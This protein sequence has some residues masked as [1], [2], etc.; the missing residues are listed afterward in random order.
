MR[1]SFQS[2]SSGEKV[3][4]RL[5]CHGGGWGRGWQHSWIRGGKA[6]CDDAREDGWMRTFVTCQTRLC[7]CVK[8]AIKNVVVLKVSGR[9]YF[10]VCRRWL[11]ACMKDAV[12]D[13]A[14]PRFEI[15]FDLCRTWSRILMNF[16][17]A[18]KCK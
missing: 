15:I 6:D 10:E 4:E 12:K 14:M 7:T 9:A 18:S 11:C 5:A 1:S 16:W 3:V 13:V 8:D 17:G 2:S